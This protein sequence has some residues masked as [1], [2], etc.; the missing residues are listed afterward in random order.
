VDVRVTACH[1]DVIPWYPTR[2]FICISRA[3]LQA[4]VFAIA[5]ERQNEGNKLNGESFS[6]DLFRAGSNLVSS[7]RQNMSD[8]FEANAS[9]A[10]VKN[11]LR[12]I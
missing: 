2:S 4:A 8:C 12:V 9:S 7:R 3:R 6:R 1:L 5:D 10:I 11:L